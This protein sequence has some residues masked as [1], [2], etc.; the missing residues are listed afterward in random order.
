MDN[1]RLSASPANEGVKRV[2]DLVDAHRVFLFMKGSPIFPQCGFS[3]KA[4]AM[5]RARGVDFGSFNV[6]SDDEVRQGAKEY[7]SWPTIPQLYVDGEFIGGSDIMA[8]MD[9]S[10]ELDVLLSSAPRVGE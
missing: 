3:A 7:A 6:L 5:L 1:Q 8:E 4:V 2:T 9:E 10:G